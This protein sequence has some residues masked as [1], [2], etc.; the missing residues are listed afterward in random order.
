[1]PYITPSYTFT[2]G[3]AGSGT[4]NLSGIA[5]FNIKKLVAVIN[6]THGIIIYQSDNPG[7]RF[8]ENTGATIRLLVDTSY[9]SSAD[10][11]QVLYDDGSSSS[12]T[13][14][15]GDV[16]GLQ[17]ALDGKQKT[18]TFGTAPPTGGS[19]GDLYIQYTA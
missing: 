16:A 2:P 3:R 12:T 19:D 4:I 8:V 17:A 5:N 9:M 13:I 6:Q 10:T 7:L 14:S 15:I 18:I 11:L 1:M